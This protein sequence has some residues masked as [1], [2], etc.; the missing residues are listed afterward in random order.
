MARRRRTSRRRK[1]SGAAGVL[2]RPFFV[3]LLRR[4]GRRPGWFFAPFG[5]AT[6]T[7]VE[8]APGSSTVQDRPAT[9]GGGHRAQPVRL[10]SDALVEAGNAQGR[11]IPLRPSGPG[12][13]GLCAHRARRCFHQNGH[14]SRGIEPLRYCRPAG[15]G[16]IWHPAEI[17]WSGAAKQVGLVADL[18][19]GAKSLE[20]YLFPDTYHFPRKFEPGADLRGH[21]EA[22][23]RG[24][25]RN[26]D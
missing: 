22:L 9:G 16:G 7:F 18:D 19:P 14:H 24:R 17:F 4:R 2:R 20:G 11:R 3:L 15:A 25:P 23:S 1:G 13:R 12:H 8:L 10:R 26:W 6:E 21:G 5:P